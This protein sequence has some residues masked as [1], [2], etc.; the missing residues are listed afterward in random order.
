M[1]LTSHPAATPTRW[2]SPAH[3]PG[4]KHCGGLLPFFPPGLGG[5]RGTPGHGALACVMLVLR[6][7]AA[8]WDSV[9]S[10]CW[11]P[12][13]A[14]LVLDCVLCGGC[15]SL[16]RLVCAPLWLLA[17]LL[18]S[19][20]ACA[21]GAALFLACASRFPACF[22]A[23]SFLSPPRLFETQMTGRGTSYHVKYTC[24]CASSRGCAIPTTDFIG[25]SFL[26]SVEER[27]QNTFAFS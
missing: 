19:V 17:P 20:S 27:C 7:C 10:L 26:V 2:L 21:A 15:F 4:V 12:L 16:F 6:S 13:G 1:P 11:W 18:C 23:T 9:S 22:P 5:F 3:R 24:M 14:L 25:N 8:T